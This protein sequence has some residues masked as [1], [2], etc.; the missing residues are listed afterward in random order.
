MTMDTVADFVEHYADELFTF[1]KHGKISLNES[2]LPFLREVLIE[3][4]KK[5]HKLK[6]GTY[7]AG[8][9]IPGYSYTLI[10]KKIAGHELGLVLECCEAQ[11]SGENC[12]SMREFF[13]TFS[14]ERIPEIS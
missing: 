1:D 6:A 9:L 7:G 10:D 12:I 3:I 11:E 8:I 14:E 5:P 4:F 13:N 2:N